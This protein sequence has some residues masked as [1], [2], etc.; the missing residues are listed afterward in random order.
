MKKI[1]I[2][3]W[4]GTGNTAKMAEA[5]ADGAKKA[6]AEVTILRVDQATKEDVMAADGIAFGCPSMGS[7]VLEEGEMEPFISMIEQEP[8][9][10]KPM[11]L[12]GSFDWGDGQWMRE[13]YER[14]KNTGAQLVAD[15][16]A[17]QNTPDQIGLSLCET[18]GNSLVH[19]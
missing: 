15:G 1:V 19:G 9:A 7:E 4:S 3:Y 11:A 10:Q 12:F 2:I 16:L 5:V 14:M 18:L 17:I 8:L 6:G 13:W